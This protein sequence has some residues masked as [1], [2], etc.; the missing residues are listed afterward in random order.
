M[1]CGRNSVPCCGALELVD[2]AKVVLAGTTLAIGQYDVLALYNLTGPLAPV[3]FG[4]TPIAIPGP[5]L[6]GVGW[7]TSQGAAPAGVALQFVFGAATIGASSTASTVWIG[8]AE[9][10]WLIR[11]PSR[12]VAVQITNGSAS[13][14]T[15]SFN[16]IARAHE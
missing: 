6:S 7:C 4:G 9:T 2:G 13:Q 12:V 5:W 15:L 16:L 8:A 3:G 14:M 1:C 10:Q 11:V